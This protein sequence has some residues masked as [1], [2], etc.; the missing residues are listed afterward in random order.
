MYLILKASYVTISQDIYSKVIKWHTPNG[1]D[2]SSDLAQTK[3]G[4]GISHFSSMYCLTFV[5]LRPLLSLK[6]PTTR[7]IAFTRGLFKTG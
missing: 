2:A 3:R 7:C 6:Q 4:W 1:F 5:P